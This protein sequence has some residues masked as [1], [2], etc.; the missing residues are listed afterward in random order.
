MRKKKIK[1][2]LFKIKVIYLHLRA[3]SSLWSTSLSNSHFFLFIDFPACLSCGILHMVSISVFS[4]TW[5]TRIIHAKV[6]V[7]SEIEKKKL[8]ILC[9][10]RKIDFSKIKIKT[11]L[12]LRQKTNVFFEWEAILNFFSYV[13][14]RRHFPEAQSKLPFCICRK[15]IT[16][17]WEQR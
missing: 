13:R 15:L 17:D 1:H 8:S 11:T 16:W 4:S 6:L 10:F 5:S 9:P 7:W 2:L 3:R 12:K 14:C